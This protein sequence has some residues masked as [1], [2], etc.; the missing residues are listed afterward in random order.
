MND[1][2]IALNHVMFQRSIQNTFALKL[3]NHAITKLLI[4]ITCRHH[5]M[6]VA[7]PG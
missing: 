1:V 5:G 7:L 2:T 3:F 4:T 6:D